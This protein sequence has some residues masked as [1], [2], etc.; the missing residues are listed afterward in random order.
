MKMT[1]SIALSACLLSIMTVN[2]FAQISYDEA[3][4][5]FVA[6]GIAYKEGRYD[7]AITGYNKILEG[8]RTSGPL[9]YNLGNSYFKKGNIGKAI[10]SYERA[11]KFMPRDSDLNFNYKYVQSKTDQYDFPGESNIFNRLI[12]GYIKFYTVDE[13]VIILAGI[14]MVM[15]ILFLVSLYARLTETIR[16]GG[17]ILLTLVLIGYGLGLVI[18]AHDETDMA[19]VMKSAESY[20]EPRTDSTVHFK[21]SEGLKTKIL[22]SEG[23]WV[24]IQRLDGKIGW[25]DRDAL[26]KI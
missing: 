13:M 1:Q 21:I 6:S 9:Q 8:G 4:S 23:H 7:A 3:L 24:K 10:L 14:I 15:G 2:G 25:I 12:H 22:K 20:F 11:M 18:K 16:V 19:V 5:E 17:L 26:E